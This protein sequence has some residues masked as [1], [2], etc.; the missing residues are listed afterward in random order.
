LE[1]LRESERVRLAMEAELEREAEACWD[2][3]EPMPRRAAATL[4]RSKELCQSSTE[5]EAL[6]PLGSKRGT[7]SSEGI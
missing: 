6:R 4:L 2:G 7:S 3:G 5:R 1:L